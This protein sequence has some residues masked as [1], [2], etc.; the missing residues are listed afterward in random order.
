[1]KN[2]NLLA[3]SVRRALWLG[4]AGT[5]MLGANVMAQET[6]KE[7]A[8][9]KS[10]EVTGSR[11]PRTQSE[12]A[13]PV[14]TVNKEA[15]EKTGALTIGDFLQDIPSISGA[16][17]NPAVNNG[18]GTGA[19]TVSLRGLGEE[20]TLI[21]INGR[22]IVT[23]DVNSIPMSM[24]QNVEVLK[25]GASAIYGSD[26]VGGVVNF[27]L[28]KNYEGLEARVDYGIS[29]RDDGQRQGASLT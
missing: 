12:N 8:T 10:V 25:D 13:S 24:V 2:R 17:T 9:L 28:S 19:A 22:R 29:S 27:I 15:I 26:A 6:A 11:I 18:G 20:R 7:P 4:V 14:Y 23:N 16:A 21:L 5:S 3:E 1:M